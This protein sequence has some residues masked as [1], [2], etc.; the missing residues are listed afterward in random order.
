MEEPVNMVRQRDAERNALEH[1]ITLPN[2]QLR[3]RY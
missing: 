1:Q 3:S 2:G